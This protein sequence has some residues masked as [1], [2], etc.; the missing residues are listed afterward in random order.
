M[1]I[2]EKK[3][4]WLWEKTHGETVYN[5]RTNRHQQLKT[6]Y[7]STTRD[8]LVEQKILRWLLLLTRDVRGLSGVSTRQQ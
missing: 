7:S 5:L 1:K 6:E 8:I 4:L 2:K 3:A